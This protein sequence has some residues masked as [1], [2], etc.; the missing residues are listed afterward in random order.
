[1]NR[2]QNSTHKLLAQTHSASH[3]EHTAANLSPAVALEDGY[4]VSLLY[5]TNLIAGTHTLAQQLEELRIYL[6]NLLSADIQLACELRVF[7]GLG[8]PHHVVNHRDTILWCHLLRCVAPRLIGADVALDD[9]SVVAE[10]GSLLCYAV[11][12]RS[13]AADVRWVAYHHHIGEA[14]THIEEQMPHRNVFAIAGQSAFFIILSAV[15]LSMFIVSLFQNLNIPIE[16]VE[17][18]LS[19]IFAPKMIDQITAYLDA[20]YQSAMGISFVSLIVTLWSASQGI[21]AITNGLNRVYDAYENRN[22]LF[23]RIRAMIYTVILFAIILALLIILVLGD[24]ISNFLKP[25]LDGLPDFVTVIFN[26]RYLIIFVSLIILLAM[27]Y[28]NFP[29]MKRKQ[30]KEY[31]IKSQLPGAFMCTISWF[32]LSLVISIYVDDFNGFSIYGGL[33]RLAVIMIWIY[34]CMVI[35]MICAE[36]NYVYHNKFKCFHLRNAVKRICKK[37]KT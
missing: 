11:E 5:L 21:H 17:Q 14:T 36:I 2:L 20:A 1:M 12:Q 31:G 22:W 23:L 9:E 37:K 34:F 13:T 25:F 27:L 19:G 28:R 3:R 4:V 26:L 7:G 16:L 8:T 10:I 29:N 18:G 32:V 33:T 35:L 24:T 6:I 15:P 30:R